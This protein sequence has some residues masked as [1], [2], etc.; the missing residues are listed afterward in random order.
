MSVGPGAGGGRRADDAAA[1]GRA[2]GA[3]RDGR[4]AGALDDDV[5]GAALATNAA[6]A[7]VV[8]EV[9]VAEVVVVAAAAGIVDAGAA[10]AVV[11]VDSARAPPPRET[12][13]TLVAAAMATPATNAATTAVRGRR[14]RGGTLPAE[15]ADIVATGANGESAAASSWT[16][17]KRSSRFFSRH[18]STHASISAGTSGR[19][20]DGGR[21]S[22][23]TISTDSAVS[24]LFRNGSARVKSW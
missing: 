7:S 15:N 1:V 16:D 2:E 20:D 3:G 24:A 13:A 10:G 4:A 11:A 23:V 8:A 22:A 5:E 9:V 17:A 14:A 18:R 6:G 12:T 19:S 21:G